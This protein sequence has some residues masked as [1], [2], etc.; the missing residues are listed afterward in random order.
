MI[1]VEVLKQVTVIY[2]HANCPDGLASAMILKDAFRMLGMA[3]RIEFLAYTKP[4]SNTKIVQ[5]YI[6]IANLDKK[7]A[8]ED[9]GL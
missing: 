9:M 2:V 8:T 5:R 1:D 4:A 3:P 6:R 7:N